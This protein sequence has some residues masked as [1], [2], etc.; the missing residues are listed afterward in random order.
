MKQTQK[1]FFSH[2]A[3]DYD[4]LKS[5][6]DNVNNIAQGILNEIAFTK[7]MSIMDFGSGT[8]L[9][10]SKIAPHV[11]EITAVDISS[12]MNEVLRSKIDT[13]NCKLDIAEMDLTKASLDKTFDAIISSM[14]FHHIEDI[15]ELFNKLYSLVTTNGLIAIAD[16]DKEDGSF[17]TSDTGVFH[18][19][20]ER[21][22]FLNFANIAGFKDLKIQTVNVMEKP[23]GTYPVFLLTG[24]K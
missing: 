15:Q 11:Q 12:S 14:T 17:H 21:E 9:L 1:D 19:G 3:K 10:L 13:I 2:K 5:R 20:F 16:I 23:T 6:T 8:G 4:Q 24:R 18:L 22:L 7:D